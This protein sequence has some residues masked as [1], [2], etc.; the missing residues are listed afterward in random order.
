MIRRCFGGGVLCLIFV[1]ICVSANADVKMDQKSQLKFG[2]MLGKMF[3]LFGGKAAKEG[4]VS[5]I[6][7]QGDRKMA[8]TDKVGEI[9]D[10]KE[11]KKYEFNLDKKTYR[12]VTFD[13]IRK[14]IE[15]A[16][17]KAEKQAARSKDANQGP[18]MEVE[19]DMKDTG[20]TK[21]ING[22]NCREVVMTIRT[23]EKGKTM[24]DAGGLILTADMWMAP[25]VSAGREIADFE[26]RYLE[27]VNGTDDAQIMQAMVMYPGLDQ[28]FAK[29]KAQSV[30][31]TGTA[32]QTVMTVE[33][34]PSK[35]QLAQ[36][37]KQEKEQE[38]G[39]GGMLG[40]FAKRLGRKKSDEQQQ[41]DSGKNNE[42]MTLSHEV[43][44]L[45]TTVSPEDITLPAGLKLKN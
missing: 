21:V 2:G 27:K 23:H 44:K 24:E 3:N 29:M 1:F 17:Q 20:Q 5:S 11:E 19:F 9:V 38:G 34:V 16:R 40:G 42:V 37:A 32:I 31:V 18:E 26:R 39:G 35:E 13:Q 6:A 7:I 45:A 8:I 10:L 22:Y 33:A 28:A 14:E 43:L 41:P 36:Q 12:V 4:L 25:E 15:E 30:N